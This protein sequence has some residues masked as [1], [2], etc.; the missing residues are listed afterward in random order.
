MAR[1]RTRVGRVEAGLERQLRESPA[2]GPAERSALRS[3]ARA[4]DVGEARGDVD[5]VTRANAVYLSLRA[6]AGMTRN[7]ER[8]GDPF[9]VFLA[10]LARASPGGRDGEVG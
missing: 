7:D 3:Q 4:V 6:A 2:I 5:A 9:D 1:I 8:A 10:D